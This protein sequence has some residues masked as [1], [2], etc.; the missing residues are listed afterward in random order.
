MDANNV[1]ARILNNGSLFWRGSPHIYNVP[2][3]GPA[4]AIFASGIWIGGMRDGTLHVAGS[5]YGPYE[6]WAGPHDVA[7]SGGDCAPFDRAYDIAYRDLNA[8]QLGTEPAAA[9]INWP[10]ELGAPVVDGDGVP[11]NY[12]LAGGDRPELLGDQSIFWVMNDAGNTHNRSGTPPLGVEVHGTAFAASS[13]NPD[14]DNTTFYRYRI[15]NK[16]DTPIEDMFFGIFSDPDLGN[17]QDDYVGSDPALNLAFV[18]NADNDDEGGEGY[19]TAPPAVGY[20]VLGSPIADADGID[21]ND[22]GTIDEPGEML[23]LTSFM[24]FTNGSGVTGDPGTGADMYNYMKGRWKDGQQATEGGNGRDFSNTPTNFMFSGTPPGY[25]SEFD[26]DGLGNAIS[27]ADRR[28]TTGIGPV[29]LPA[30]GE[31]EIFFAVVTAF[32][33]DNLDSVVQLKAAASRLQG[34]TPQDVVGSG[35]TTPP[36]TEVSNLLSPADGATGVALGTALVWDSAS[37][38]PE[39]QVQ[40]WPA[41]DP[42]SVT[43]FEV[44]GTSTGASLAPNETYSFRVRSQNVS[45]YGPWS[46]TNTFTTGQVD[47]AGL[48]GIAAFLATANG[49]GAINPPTGAAADFGGFPV[50]ERPGAS[51]QVGDGQWLIHTGGNGSRSSYDDFVSRSVRFGVGAILPFSYEVRFTGSSLGYLRFSSRGLIQPELPFEIWNI[52]TDLDS[53]D[54]DIRMIP[55]VLDWEDDGFGLRAVDHEVSGGSNDPQTD[56]LYWYHPTDMSPG[57]AGYDAWASSALG[58][59]GESGLGP[60]VFGRMVFVNWNGGDTTADPLLF[61]QDL[62]EP[63]TIFRIVTA[64]PPAPLLASPADGGLAAPGLVPFFWDSFSSEVTLEVT[65]DA[66]FNSITHSA[67]DVGPGHTLD[68]IAGDWYWRVIDPAS[69][70]SLEWAFEVGDF[71]PPTPTL[72]DFSAG[73][74]VTDGI[75]STSLS[76]GMRPGATDGLDA[77]FDQLAPPAPPAG[78]F[79]ARLES[80]ADQ[81]LADHRDNTAVEAQWTLRWQKATGGGDIVLTWDPAEFPAEGTITLGDNLGGAVLPPFDMRGTNTW[82]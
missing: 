8:L 69:G 32:G 34:L 59:D 17:F 12:N 30:G 49:A 27:P 4:Q 47:F 46:Q 70:S 68:L 65:T 43:E 44:T 71:G 11:G 54:D 76:F 53:P 66:T 40:L 67:Q 78:S 22:D 72:P 2:K 16:N 45:G 41:A 74:D 48:E 82:T 39:F 36:P 35:A 23:G 15:I 9:V 64:T 58:G 56:W 75:G 38:F 6:F 42:S 60:E 55:A 77:S 63:G 10:W 21:N 24:F 28:F 50:P 3:G 1:R 62:P 37:G 52:G 29:N 5:T 51:Q 26:F 73:L 79:D 33:A 18:Y 13:S 81:F 14:I 31:T 57:T 20:V 61:N 7:A 80:P 25:W 19:G